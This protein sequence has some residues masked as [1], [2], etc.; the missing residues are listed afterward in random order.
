MNYTQLLFKTE[1]YEVCMLINPDRVCMLLGIA[2]PLASTVIFS[3]QG[4]DKACISKLFEC[5]MVVRVLDI[6]I[7]HNLLR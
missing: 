1:V 6:I 3:N 5:C 7:V 4:I 2:C